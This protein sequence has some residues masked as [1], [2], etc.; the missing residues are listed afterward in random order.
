VPLVVPSALDLAPN[1]VFDNGAADA[2]LAQ[3]MIRELRP[4]AHRPSFRSQAL[5]FS[6]VVSWVIISSPFPVPRGA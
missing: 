2:N 3:R 5:I 6:E 4:F 1:D